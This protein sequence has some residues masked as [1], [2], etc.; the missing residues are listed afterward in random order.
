MC[1]RDSSKPD[2]LFERVE[3]FPPDKQ[4]K[5]LTIT[6]NPELEKMVVYARVQIPNNPKKQGKPLQKYLTQ[7]FE[8]FDLQA[9]RDSDTIKGYYE[10]FEER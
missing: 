10:H 9:I 4:E 6:V 8:N 1:I 2:I 7:R 3:Y 5:E